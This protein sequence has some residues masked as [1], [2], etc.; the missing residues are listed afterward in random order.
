MNI[1]LELANS[2]Y[3]VRVPRWKRRSFFILVVDLLDSRHAIETA[4]GI[5]LQKMKLTS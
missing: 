2:F 3:G 5:A 4:I 1:F